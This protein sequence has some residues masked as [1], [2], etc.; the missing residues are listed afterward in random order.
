M[1]V[2]LILELDEVLNEDEVMIG[3]KT[4]GLKEGNK[5]MLGYVAI[6]KNFNLYNDI[7]YANLKATKYDK[8]KLNNT[9]L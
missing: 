8:Q 5:S 3:I 2:P 7:R 9:A 1:L 4:I 6:I